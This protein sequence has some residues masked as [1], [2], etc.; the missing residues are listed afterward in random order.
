MDIDYSKDYYNILGLEKNASETEIKKAYRQLQMQHHPDRRGGTESEL[1]KE[2]NDAYS[3][4]SDKQKKRTYDSLRNNPFMNIMSGAGSSGGRTAQQNTNMGDLFTNMFSQALNDELEDIFNNQENLFSD[5]GGPKIHVFSAGIPGGSGSMQFGLN[6]MSRESLNSN[7]F[8]DVK[9]KKEILPEPIEK[10]IEI[11]LE[12]SF[13]GCNIPVNIERIIMLNGER[14]KEEETIYVDISRGI[15]NNE[16]IL[17]DKKGHNI[18]NNIGQVKLFIKITNNTNFERNGL[19]LIYNK[20]ITFKESLCGFSFVLDYID[21][22]SFTLNSEG[23]TI[24][25]TNYKKVIPNM[26]L[27]R[28]DVKGNL[29]IN[30]KVSYPDKLTE[31]QIEKLKEIL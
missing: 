11:S 24:I 6:N 20:T 25:F 26:G 15:D 28:N 31:E 27:E 21:G 12:Q 23:G 7:M 19:N 13:S 10:V 17:L 29:I 18:N 1:S 3:I 5:G 8:K 2:L 22:R 14:K 16:I 30:F 9:Y 4:L